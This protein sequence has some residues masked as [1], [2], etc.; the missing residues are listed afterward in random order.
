MRKASRR[1]RRAGPDRRAERAGPALRSDLLRRRRQGRRRRAPRGQ[2]RARGRPRR[3]GQ[4]A[5]DRPHPAEARG[6]RGWPCPRICRPSP[7]ASPAATPGRST[8]RAPTTASTSSRCR[9]GRPSVDRAHPPRPPRPSRTAAPRCS[10]RRAARASGPSAASRC[11]RFC[12]MTAERELLS[13]H[14][15]AR[16]DLPWRRT[17]D[18]WAVLVSEVML[19]QTQVARVRE[20]WAA[21]M[22]RW[23]TPAALAAADR[24]DVVR[25]WQGLGYNRRAV[26]LHRA[27][28][29]IADAGWPQDLTELPGVGRYTADAVARFA[30]GRP[31]LPVDVNVAPGAGA[32]RRGVRPARRRGADGP[33]R[34]RL[35]RA[36]AALRRLPARAALPV[37]RAHLRPAAAPVAVRGLVPPAPRPDAA[38]PSW[39][40]GRTRTPASRPYAHSLERDGLSSAARRSPGTRARCRPRR[41][42]STGSRPSCRRRSRGR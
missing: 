38:A 40:G 14:R 5:Q 30:L 28:A 13:W 10:T 3:P 6:H 15:S 33:G 39:T 34:H 20:R 9:P 27:A 42:P 23:P 17:R 41:C 4:G 25:A 31:V 2:G 36:G 16:R 35:H 18:P 19:Q 37:Q 32:H 21:W 11:R 26:G 22:E 29:Q 12:D 8:P 7:S 24:D 1:T